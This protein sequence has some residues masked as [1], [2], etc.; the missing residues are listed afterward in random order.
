MLAA[1]TFG[2]H[3]AN[4]FPGLPGDF[5]DAPDQLLLLAF[6]VLQIVIGELGELLFKFALGDVPVALQLECDHI[7]FG[8]VSGYICHPLKRELK[9]SFAF[10]V[11]RG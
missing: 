4:L 8:L 9:H 7:V 2:H 11:P 1:A 6:D 5:L 10:G 3:N